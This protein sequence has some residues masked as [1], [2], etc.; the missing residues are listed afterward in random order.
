MSGRHRAF[1]AV[2]YPESAPT[3]FRDLIE[4]FDV[5]A[6]LILHDQDEGKKPHYHLL[7]MF[8]SMKSLPQ[9]HNLTDQL[10]SK[11]LQPSY[12]MRA[13]ARY[14]LHRDHPDKFQY[15]FSAL[16]AFSGA[17][18]LDLTQPLGDPSPEMMAFIREQG[19]VE[20]SDLIDYCL[21]VRPEWYIW[22][23]SHTVY[24]LGYFTSVRY[25]SM[26]GWG[27]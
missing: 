7:L 24:L 19:M 9:V 3:D 21:D 1:N 11:E 8:S 25:K 17:Q 16:E 15:P 14:L 12:D 18:A 13:S 10:G 22:A 4:S 26:R 20:Y 23:R 2:F 27:K 6:L 5:P